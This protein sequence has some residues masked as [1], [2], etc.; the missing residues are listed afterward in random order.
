MGLEIERLQL[1]SG[2]RQGFP[3]AQWPLLSYLGWGLIP[4]TGAKS[5][6]VR[7]ELALWSHTARKQGHGQILS[8]Y[9]GIR[10]GGTA[11]VR[12]WGCF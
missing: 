4:S 8:I 11:T 10:C 1:T 9:Q 5:M 3:S 6:K 12:D 7:P 2:M